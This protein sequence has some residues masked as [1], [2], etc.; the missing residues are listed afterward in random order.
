MIDTASP[1][2]YSRS[3]RKSNWRIDF[4]C[5]MLLIHLRRK[6]R[7]KTSHRVRELSPTFLSKQH[8]LSESRVSTT[9][10]LCLHAVCLCSISMLLLLFRLASFP[11]SNSRRRSRPTNTERWPVRQTIQRWRNSRSPC[12]RNQ[13]KHRIYCFRSVFTYRRVQQ[14]IY[15]R[16]KTIVEHHNGSC[17]CSIS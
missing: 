8:A 3:Q 10:A 9:S 11:I 14:H 17:V 13:N 12:S 1:R 6:E 4:P 15:A 5:C 2:R 7:R 16:G